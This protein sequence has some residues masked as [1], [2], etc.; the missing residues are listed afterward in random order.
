MVITTPAGYVLQLPGTADE[1]RKVLAER[2][3]IA[4]GNIRDAVIRRQGEVY[5]QAATR[6]MAA[7]FARNTCNLALEVVGKVV[8]AYR[9][10]PI[11][12]VVDAT[13]DQR[14]QLA[15][16]IDASRLPA[17]MPSLARLS[18]WC[19]PVLMLP[20]PDGDAVRWQWYPPSRTAVVRRG[21]S[22]VAAAALVGKVDGADEVHI[23]DE[24]GLVRL[25]VWPSGDTRVLA[26]L[27][28]SRCL[29][30][31]V[32]TRPIDPTGDDTAF[33]NPLHDAAVD[34]GYVEA[35]LA[36]RRKSQSGKQ[37]A[38][39]GRV[40]SN[41]QDSV[42]TQPI[43]QQI[44]SFDEG[45]LEFAENETA[46]VLD[47]NTPPDTFIRHI[48][49]ITTKCLAAYGLELAAPL[50]NAMTFELSGA[51]LATERHTQALELAACE[52]QAIAA[53]IDGAEAW[54]YAAGLPRGRILVFF[55]EQH[56]VSDPLR[57]EELYKAKAA[58]GG[59]NPVEAYMLDHPGATVDE[60]EAA[61]AEN[62]RRTTEITGALA[63]RR[64]LSPAN[65]PQ[66]IYETEAQ[67]TGREG[68]SARGGASA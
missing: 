66:V 22:V 60:A 3:R 6:A 62:I 33:G 64:A 53:L 7:R 20:W 63:D 52:R 17:V 10:Q 44:V 39:T 2:E 34:A 28:M 57:R 24:T 9:S 45:A 27:P 11:R 55:Q 46:V 41:A 68:G 36:A 38:T 42:G 37:L 61:V 30:V 4:A 26:E 16:L 8:T 58:R 50:N 31:E 13:P 54:G 47:L 23:A 43:H 15:D 35:D 18:W 14:R 25:L 67:T 5:M 59:T 40:F 12:Q 29:A 51:S 56:A 48:E 32:R 49:H 1:S 65:A 19:G 21:D